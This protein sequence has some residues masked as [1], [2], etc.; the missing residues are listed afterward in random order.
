[1]ILVLLHVVM[2]LACA[3][4]ILL[5]RH[6]QPES[7]MAWLT[8]LVALPYVG[9]LGYLLLGTT[10][11]GHKRIARLHDTRKTLPL[12][13]CAQ[14]WDASENAIDDSQP[15]ETLF[16]VGQSISGYVP[17]GGN[18]AELMA[19]SDT[20]IARM[21]EDIDGARSTVH[22]LFYIWLNDTNGMRVADALCRAAVRGVEC[23]ALVDDI[24]SRSFIRSDTWRQLADAGVQLRKALPVG[25]PLVRMVNG[26]ID[27]RNHRKIVVIDNRVTFCGSQNCADPAFAPK[28]RYGPWV[29]AVMRFEGPVVRQNQHLFAMDWMG[30]GGDNIAA[31]LAEP[32]PPPQAGFA[33]QVVATGPTGRNAAMPE[34]FTSLMFAARHDLFVTTPYYVPT[35]AV[36][37]A[38][39]AAANRGVTTTVIFPA[40]NDDFAVGAASR[41]YYEGLLSAG[42]RI[43]EY[44]AGLLHTKSITLDSELTLIGSANMDRRSFDLN[45]ENNILLHDRKAT[46]A[47][48]AR[49]E[50]Y[51]SDCREVTAR[52]VAEWSMGRRLWNN[53]LAIVSPVL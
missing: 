4:H 3:L 10:N 13:R 51:L 52:E 2:V 21:V 25:N 35:P 26:R 34:M 32:L 18:R 28:A 31:L 16:R 30:N 39:C 53:A 17:V 24:G 23:R 33:A 46:A 38:L 47:M 42:V 48:R 45:Y 12:P 41:S 50:E 14:G 49:Q 19:D 27:L 15:Y 5:R 6:R 43:F 40:R 9:V 7:R 1:M 44:G 29:D 36:Q 22:L 20:T 11:I 8:V 37:A